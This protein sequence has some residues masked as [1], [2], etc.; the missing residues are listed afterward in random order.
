MRQLTKL[1]LLTLIVGLLSSGSLAQKSVRTT[2]KASPPI[3]CDV[4]AVPKGMVVVGYSRN[5][6]C[7]D[8]VELVVKRPENGDIICTESPVP[9]GF[10]IVSDAQ[11]RSAG[12]CSAGAY[13][14]V[15]R[16]SSGAAT[17]RS[18]TERRYASERRSAT[19][20]RAARSVA[21]DAIGRAF[22]SGVS[23][24]QVD[25]EGVVIR[26]LSD[27]LNGSRHQRF[28]IELASGQTLLISHNIDLAP[29]LDALADGDSVRFSGEY[30]WNE[31]GGLIHWTH[32]DPRG[33]HTAGWIV[34]NGKTYQ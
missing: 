6:A 4:D 20:R 5:A 27:D 13:L 8:G 2:R 28:I 26:L 23:N 29:R 24:I 21:D 7:S 19:E 16:A 34:H 33:R 25:G 15:G 3:V 10:S 12:T 1:L 30:V 22:A 31:K 14:I 11:G 18:A 17:K 32:R 9:P